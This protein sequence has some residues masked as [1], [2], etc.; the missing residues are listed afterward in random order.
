[1]A[2]GKNGQQ[3]VVKLHIFK[4]DIF[5]YFANNVMFQTFQN[6]T[7]TSCEGIFGIPQN[8]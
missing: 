2:S 7:K 6:P 8:T 4:W 3:E 5:G 1:M